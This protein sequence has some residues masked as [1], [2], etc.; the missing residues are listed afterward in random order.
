MES[1]ISVWSP[2]VNP[3]NGLSQLRRALS[4]GYTFPGAASLGDR[5]RWKWKDLAIWTNTGSYKGQS[6]LRISLPMQAMALTGLHHCNFFLDP[7]PVYSSLFN[8][9]P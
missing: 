4:Q 2:A 7:V 8:V 6:V 9:D 5:M 1:I 3:F